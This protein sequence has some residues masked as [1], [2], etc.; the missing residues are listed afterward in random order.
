VTAG[1]VEVN[2]KRVLELGLKIDLALDR[3]RVDGRPVELRPAGLEYWLVHKPRDMMTTLSD[4]QARP[5]VRRLVSDLGV[6]LFPV[7]RLDY[8]AE[9]LLLMTNDGDLTYRLTHP[10]F[11]VR[12]T[13][14]VKV[15]GVPTDAEL[16]SLSSGIDLPDGRVDPI[17]VALQA[18]RESSAWIRIAVAEGRPHLVKR[19]C[20]AIGRR[21]LRL[22]R[23]EYGG[24]ILA[25]LRSGARRRLRPE[26]LSRLR[27]EAAAGHAPAAYRGV[28]E[29]PASISP[30]RLK[31]HRVRER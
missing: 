12:R 3:V 20:E 22:V 27:K 31:G 18:T 17:E 5:T 23:V 7:G 25:D 28:L 19:L 9:G 11:Q 21:V 16:T 13:Y 1:R 15:R 2:G 30:S 26:E 24:L 6:R 4:P 29:L 8:D 14:L 10:K